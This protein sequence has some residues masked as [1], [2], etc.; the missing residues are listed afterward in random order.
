MQRASC[1]IH[2]LG[3]AS[4]S[5]E[6]LVAPVLQRGQ[7]AFLGRSEPPVPQIDQQ[8]FQAGAQLPLPQTKAA[9]F[10]WGSELPLSTTN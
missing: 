2:K 9:S 10:L 3:P 8:A 7:Q 4:C 1:L 5:S 6:E